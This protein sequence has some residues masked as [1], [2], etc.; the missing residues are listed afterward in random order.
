MLKVVVRVSG[1]AYGTSQQRDA[2]TLGRST[3]HDQLNVASRS[4]A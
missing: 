3:N 1:I 4:D 2:Q